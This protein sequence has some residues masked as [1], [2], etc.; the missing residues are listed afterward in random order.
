MKRAKYLLLLFMVGVAVVLMSGCLFIPARPTGT[1]EGYVVDS[2]AGSP[3]VGAV[4]TAFPLNDGVPST[5]WVSSSYRRPTATTDEEGHYKLVLPEGTYTVV[6]EKEGFATTRIEG[7]V[8]A[9]TVK[10]DVIEKPVF[11]P[12][13]SLEPPEVTVTIEGQV[14]TPG[15]KI[16]LDAV[17]LADG[18]NYRVDAQGPNDINIIYAA[19]GKTPG[20]RW[21][22]GTREIFTSTYTTGDVTMDPAN[23]GVEGWTTFEVVVYD[24]NENRTHILFQVYIP[25]AAGPPSLN[26]PQD[27]SVLAVTLGKK[28]SF[29]GETITVPSGAGDLK[30]QAAPEGGNLYVELKWKPSADDAVAGGSGITGYRIYRKL[31]GEADYT[32]I[33]TVAQGDL[34]YDSDGDYVPDMYLFRDSSPSLSP[35]IEA[36]YQV[37][38]YRGNT[39]SAPV[40]ASTTPLDIWD[41]RL[42]QPADGATNVGLNPVFRWEPTRIVGNDQYYLWALWDHV[43][44]R[45]L[46]AEDFLNRTEFTYSPDEP[47]LSWIAQTPFER[48]QPHR[49]YQWYIGV[50]V[51]YDDFD[52]PT[53][54]S[55]AIQDGW[56]GPDIPVVPV[57]PATDFFTFTTGDW[58]E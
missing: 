22:T 40:E 58:P 17:Q 23:Y 37:R 39:E 57:L 5:Y 26:P 56:I 53:A 31:A 14:V 4:V 11:N 48:L 36:T 42:L 12:G 34:R 33:G 19:L 1:V 16:V 6:V 35:G 30:I 43:L 45:Y 25:E 38:A 46:L 28:V 27:F 54:M 29:Y 50:A 7:V 47:E 20:A 21:L 18:L 32:L 10:L 51:A 3:V 49:T 41:V 15:D 55:V 8:V 13:W 2:G 24:M 52:N 44:G 9:S